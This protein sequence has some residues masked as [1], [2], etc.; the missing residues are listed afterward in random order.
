VTLADVGDVSRV[1][2]LAVAARRAVTPDAQTVAID[3]WRAGDQP[4]AVPQG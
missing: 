1:S 3:S 4:R 2:P